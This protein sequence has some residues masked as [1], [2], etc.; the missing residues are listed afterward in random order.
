MTRLKF[1]TYRT[2]A[3]EEPIEVELNENVVFYFSPTMTGI[4]LLDTLEGIDS[5]SNAIA[6]QT[7]KGL[8]RKQLLDPSKSPGP[9]HPRGQRRRLLQIRRRPGQPHRSDQV[10][11]HRQRDR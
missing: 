6:S 10:A 8:F 4:E 9:G 1:S 7:I 11:G 5:S 2:T 3:V